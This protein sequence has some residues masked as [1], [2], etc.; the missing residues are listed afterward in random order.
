MLTVV[1]VAY[2]KY[3]WQPEDFYEFRLNHARR[4]AAGKS[5]DD[6][7]DDIQ[8][9]TLVAT[10]T[11]YPAAAALDAGSG[12]ED[13]TTTT[14]TVN[15]SNSNETATVE[16]VLLVA[17]SPVPAPAAVASLSTSYP[18]TNVGADGNNDYGRNDPRISGL[19]KRST[20]TAFERERGGK[21]IHMGVRL[22]Y[23]NPVSSLTKSNISNIT[24]IA[25]NPRRKYPSLSI[26]PED[27][28]RESLNLIL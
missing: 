24:C 23:G 7:D 16:G 17:A 2:V 13:T 20:I 1:Y 25:Q 6:V 22:R 9:S 19:D 26:L 28:S 10:P 27:E 14:L 11:D 21:W 5:A 12:P 4:Q 18:M 15:T 3:R 8:R